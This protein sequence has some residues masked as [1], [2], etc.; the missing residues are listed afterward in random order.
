[1][2]LDVEARELHLSHSHLPSPFHPDQPYPFS[3]QGFELSAL[4]GA[5]QLMQVISLC[6]T[7]AHALCLRV[8]V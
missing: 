1:M 3:T 4:R 7:V 5:V 6:V 8:V 2:K